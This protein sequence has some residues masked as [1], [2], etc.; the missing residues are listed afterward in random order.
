MPLVQ[1]RNVDHNDPAAPMPA[2]LVPIVAR[3]QA[4]LHGWTP[5]QLTVN[6]YEAG[7]GLSP[8]IDTH[9]AFAGEYGSTASRLVVA[10]AACGAA[11][12][13]CSCA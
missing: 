4:A 6:D 7:V 1:T 13:C 11:G 8:H 9:S 12:S 5:D 3:I 10:S 2:I